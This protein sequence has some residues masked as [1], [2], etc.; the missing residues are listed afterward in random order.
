M[1][2]RT[3]S[4][5]L[6]WSGLGLTV[7][8]TIAGLLLLATACENLTTD[9]PAPADVATQTT[10]AEVTDSAQAFFGTWEGTY[11]VREVRD[12]N[13]A[14]TNPP[15]PLNTPLEMHL[16]LHAWSETSED[17]GT[18]TVAGYPNGRVLGLSVE[19][20]EAR[21]SIVNEQEGLDD[22][23]SLMTLML[24]GD[25][26]SGEDEPDPDV[27]RGW[28]GTAGS[29]YLTRAL[30][31]ATSDTGAGAGGRRGI[32][33]RARCRPI[34]LP[35]RLPSERRESSRWTRTTTATPWGCTWVTS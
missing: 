7:A 31:A 19:G 6:G 15:V 3:R 24:Q 13:G 22:L 23:R 28:Y 33:R 29:V 26:L 4:S 35:R 2:G 1:L 5:A 16:E 12:Q 9:T 30:S 20:A 21:L 32:P 8:L 17:C 27:P 18:V 11:T 34:S 10:V 14:V 25:T